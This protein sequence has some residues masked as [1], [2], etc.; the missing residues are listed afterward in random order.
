MRLGYLRDCALLSLC[1]DSQLTAVHA[2]AAGRRYLLRGAPP[3]CWTTGR[4][5]HRAPKLA[6]VAELATDRSARCCAQAKQ[7]CWAADRQTP[8]QG[9]LQPCWT[10]WPSSPRAAL[11][12]GRGSCPRCRWAAVPLLPACSGAESWRQIFALVQEAMQTLQG[13]FAGWQACAMCLLSGVDPQLAM[14]AIWACC[15]VSA[16]DSPAGSPSQ[17]DSVVGSAPFLLV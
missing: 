13:A 17:A 9:L 12:S 16:H 3:P 2:D 8:L 7:C 6:C 11:C 5:P 14:Y 4:S 15:M 1:P 10:I